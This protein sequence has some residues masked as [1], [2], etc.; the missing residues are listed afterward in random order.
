MISATRHKPTSAMRHQLHAI[1]PHEVAIHK[2]AVAIHKVTHS[3]RILFLF[4]TLLSLLA[5]ISCY[6]WAEHEAPAPYLPNTTNVTTPF[7]PLTISSITE[8]TSLENFIYYLPDNEGTFTAN[9]AFSMSDKFITLKNKRVTLHTKTHWYAIHLANNTNIPDEWF[10]ATGVST[11]PL[12]RAYWLNTSSSNHSHAEHQLITSRMAYGFPTLLLPLPLKPG[13]AGVL[14]IEYQSLANFPLTLHLYNEFHL[15]DKSQHLKLA[16]GIYMGAMGVLF[17]FFFGQFLIGRTVVYF[18]YSMFVFFTILMVMQISGVNHFFAPGSLA[19]TLF[20]TLVGGGIYTFYF[21]FAAEFFQLKN[22][23]VFLYR[24]LITLGTVVLAISAIN[25]IHPT[26][27][28]LSIVIAI[29]LPWPIASAVWAWQQKNSSAI[30]F[31]IGSLAH[32]ISTYLLLLACL[33]FATLQNEFLFRIA[34]IGLMIDILCF[35]VAIIYHNNQVR[36]NYSRQL[37]ER[38]ND[39]NALTESEQMSS[40]ALTLSKQAVLNLAATAHDLQ[41]PLSSMQILLSLQNAADPITQNVQGA[42]NYACSLL[43]SALGS[44]KQ[45]YKMISEYIDAHTLLHA[46]Q[47]RHQN[48]FNDKKLNLR[49]RC[50]ST[51][52]ICLPIVINRILDNLLSNAYKYTTQGK[53]LISGRLR[54]NGT[55]LIQVWDTGRGMDHKQVSKLTTPFE[56]MNNT[57]EL[58][59]GL[60]LFI[61]KSLCHQAGYPFS[62]HSKEHHGS[63]F[64][65]LIPHVK[66]TQDWI[67]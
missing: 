55:F 42:L 7:T 59:F 30:F 28:A 8:K 12:L 23:N 43:N 41:Q 17:L 36:L 46:A 20:T 40:K 61:V 10:I 9:T 21:F 19:Q 27:Y 11:A 44:A 52:I 64:S 57:E 50:K 15:L 24:A 47:L 1:L 60:G 22:K 25:F 16:N 4:R 3:G 32:C 5:I 38:I 18:Y 2:V 66:P 49:L 53:I 37:Q 35:A 54:A 13:D 65:V 31:L 26:A 48:N 56:R 67:D 34:C 63:C 39:L 33:G 14:F 45:D 58:G 62:I 6:T 51:P 29:G